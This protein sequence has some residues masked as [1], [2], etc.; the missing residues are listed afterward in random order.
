LYNLAIDKLIRVV[1]FVMFDL[2]G[3]GAD[4]SSFAMCTNTALC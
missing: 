3:D 1:V 4:V 2:A